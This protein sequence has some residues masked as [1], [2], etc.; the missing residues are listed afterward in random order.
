MQV[1]VSGDSL[2]IFPTTK[3]T[4]KV[5]VTA[6]SFGGSITDSLEVLITNNT[7]IRIAQIPDNTFPDGSKNVQL[8]NLT[9]IF[10]DKDNDALAYEFSAHSDLGITLNGTVLTANT[11]EGFTGTHQVIVKAKDTENAAA[12]DTF[13]ITLTEVDR[14]PPELNLGALVIP[15]LGDARIKIA[16]NENLG[17]ASLK[18]NNQA[19]ALTKENNVYFGDVNLNG[20]ATL[21][22][23][24]IASDLSGNADTLNKTYNI[25]SIN[26]PAQIGRLTVKTSKYALASKSDSATIPEN[27]V[28]L[29]NIIEIS[30]DEFTAKYHLPGD[31]NKN[32]AWIGSSEDGKTWE[33]ERKYDGN[34][35]IEARIT[36]NKKVALFYDPNA[37]S[38]KSFS[39]SQNYPNPFNPTTAITYELPQDIHV[40]LEIYN[41]LG[42]KVTT[43]I[44]KKQEAGKHQ[45]IFDGT[46]NG[47][48]LSSGIYIYM[49]MTPAWSKSAKMTLS[50]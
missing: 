18:A 21:D 39:L 28:A 6:T 35:N 43:L 25:A 29:E 45:V 10:Y 22:I 32:N 1:V 14:T 15:G 2:Y 36:G 20:A 24:A 5:G 31:I 3:G 41:I 30:G 40:K 38:P 37:E 44:D 11:L 8:A 26:K 50:K 27:M 42:Q 4:K 34:D 17:A 16:A 12:S 49:L 48:Q 47:R 23:E 46:A 13:N 7:P 33:V 19:I 9:E